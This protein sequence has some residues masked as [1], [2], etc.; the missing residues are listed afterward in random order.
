MLTEPTTNLEK[1][2]PEAHD[3]AAARHG[4]RRADRRQCQAER[5][6]LHG[7]LGLSAARVQRPRDGLQGQRQLRARQDKITLVLTT[8][9]KE[10]GPLN[11]HLDKHGDGVKSVALWVPNARKSFEETTK[12]GA[13]AEFEFEVRRDADGE[14][15]L[16]AIK[17]YGDTVHVFIERENYHGVFL[18]GYRAWN[19]DFKPA[20][21]GLQV[22]RPHGRQRRL[23]RDEHLAQVLRR[24]DGICSAVC[25]STTR[26]FPPNTPRSCPR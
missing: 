1:V 23:G 24:G 7:R 10:G 21:V 20:P 11:A 17:T 12:R 16:S 5:L 14:V 19:P 18:P 25:R 13:V 6:L 2:V 26:T 4:P 15:V 3:F 8:P 22:H 9:L